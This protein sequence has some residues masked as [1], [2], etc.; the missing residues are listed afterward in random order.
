MTNSVL[1]IL[2]MENENVN[3][4]KVLQQHG[5]ISVLLRKLTER[6]LRQRKVILIDGH[7]DQR[8]LCHFTDVL[9]QHLCAGGS[10]V[11]NGQLAYPIFN[12]LAMF[13]VAKGRGFKDL[14]IERV[15]EHPIF[16]HVDC[17]DISVKRGVAGFYGR[18]ANPPPAGAVILHRLIQDH[19]PVDW[20]W[21][22]PEG[23][24]IFM[25]SG[26]NIWL[27]TNDSTSAK[28]IVPQLI[29]WSLAG[30]PYCY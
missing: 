8:A 26:N 7:I 16:K 3:F 24:Q 21:Q 2:A 10:I 15:H 30:A 5:I 4:R 9:E 29:E 11:F 14:L 19:S 28:H 22:R 6:H 23:G 18:G 20:V 12:G 13:Q 1:H 25:H 27:Y 17:Q